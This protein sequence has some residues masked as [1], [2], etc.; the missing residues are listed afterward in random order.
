MYKYQKEVIANTYP[1]SYKG[2]TFAFMLK[3]YL[4]RNKVSERTLAKT[5][6]TSHTVVN[7]LASGHVHNL[8][9]ESALKICI[10]LKCSLD[11]LLPIVK[12]D[13]NEK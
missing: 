1:R 12:L 10:E 6:G 13:V 4:E 8:S 3:D 7:K 11:D 5:I 2:H 9:L